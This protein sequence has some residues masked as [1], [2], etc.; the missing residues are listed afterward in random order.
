MAATGTVG[1]GAR[2]MAATGT[3]REEGSGSDPSNSGPV[4]GGSGV[5]RTQVRE[6]L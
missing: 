4:N 5:E 6:Q 3:V 2:V 1:G